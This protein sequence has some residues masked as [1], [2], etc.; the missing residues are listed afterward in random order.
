MAMGRPREFD[1][2]KALD[3]SGGF[4]IFRK[5]GFAVEAYPVDFR[6][7]GTADLAGPCGSRAAV[8]ARTDAAGTHLDHYDNPDTDSEPTAYRDAA[9][10][11]A[12]A[13][14]SLVRFGLRDYEAP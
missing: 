1:V 2:D 14:T 10:W 12:D 13:A 6:T 4:G 9:G 5:A 3:L 7:R 8:L 11:L